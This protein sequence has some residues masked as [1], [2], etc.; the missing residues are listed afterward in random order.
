[1]LEIHVMLEEGFDERTNEIVALRSGK[2]ELE[3]SLVSLSKWESKYKKA[4]LDSN[5]EK[6]PEMML[7]Y[8]RYMVIDG[9]VDLIDSLSQDDVDKI[10][11]HI[12]DPHTATWFNEDG[13]NKPKKISGK[14]IT[15]DLIYYWMSALTIPF[16]CETWHL[17]RLI[18]LIR[19]A[20]AENRPKKNMSRKDA[21]SRHRS[22]NAARRGR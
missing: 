20:E 7:D 2:L 3:H 21:M 5:V 11:E 17:N 19:I 22:M 18:T 15:S 6:T 9:D 13:P 14:I 16:T 10:S 12:N 4:F 8:I 1:M